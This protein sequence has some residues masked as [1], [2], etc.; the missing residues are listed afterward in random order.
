MQQLLQHKQL[1]HAVTLRK[2]YLNKFSACLSN[3]RKATYHNSTAMHMFMRMRF[4]AAKTEPLLLP[5]TMQ[6]S[7]CTTR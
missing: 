5:S 1:L 2:S 4:T 6:L 3:P 7:H